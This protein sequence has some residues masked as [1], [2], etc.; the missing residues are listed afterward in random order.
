MPS[1][2]KLFFTIFVISLVV[3]SL[4]IDIEQ[5]IPGFHS[6]MPII[7]VPAVI[8][9]IYETKKYLKNKPETEIRVRNKNNSYSDILPYIAGSIMIIFSVIGF[10]QLESEKG[11]IILYI[12]AGLI[13]IFQGIIS[14]PNAVI[15]Y[16]NENLKFDNG[17]QKENIEVVLIKDVEVSE[18]Q[19]NVKTIDDKK[20]IFQHLELNQ[21]EIEMV[22]DFFK[23][24]IIK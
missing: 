22:N 21:S 12:I 17:N 6:Y 5:Y 7:W 9:D 3:L 8:F 14:L 20:F 13:L 18:D 4:F 15:K 10:F 24:Y 11:I 2:R 1:I 19:I 16:E 23:K